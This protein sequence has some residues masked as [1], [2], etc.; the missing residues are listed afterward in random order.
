MPRIVVGGSP[1]FVGGATAAGVGVLVVLA[2]LVAALVGR[3]VEVEDGTTE[4]VDWTEN[5]S[6]P[7]TAVASFQLFAFALNIHRTSSSF[8][9]DMT[10]K[11]LESVAIE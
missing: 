7:N 4:G 2:A 5:D 3:G 9:P 1:D 6:V 8:P 11:P 10:T